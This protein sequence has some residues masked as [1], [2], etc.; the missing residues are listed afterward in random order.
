MK[1]MITVFLLMFSITA[2]SQKMLRGIV[3]DSALNK[4]IPRASIFLN[5]TSIGTRTDD[6]GKFQ[7]SIPQGKYEIIISCVGYETFNSIIIANEQPDF[8][9]IEL[10]Q[11]T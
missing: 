10:K 5:N 7:L 9:R 6:E 3:I 1:R 8:K 11:K 2:F 4:P